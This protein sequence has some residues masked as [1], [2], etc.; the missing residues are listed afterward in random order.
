MR[1]TGPIF[2]G[3]MMTICLMRALFIGLMLVAL[4]MG[5]STIQAESRGAIGLI[6]VAAVF[7]CCV[8]GAFSST[9]RM[10]VRP[11]QPSVEEDE[12]DAD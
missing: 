1:A 6:A 10:F 11:S 4:F 8:A 2:W 5:G 7:A 12:P 9:R 3:S